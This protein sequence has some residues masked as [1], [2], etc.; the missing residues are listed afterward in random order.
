M[1]VEMVGLGE[2]YMLGEGMVVGMSKEGECIDMRIV[3]EVGME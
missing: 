2:L 1:E 3:V